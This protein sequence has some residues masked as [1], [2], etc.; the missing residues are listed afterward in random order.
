MW[1]LVLTLKNGEELYYC[2]TIKSSNNVKIPLF[3]DQIN[4][5]NIFD[6]NSSAFNQKQMITNNYGLNGYTLEVTSSSY[7]QVLM[8]R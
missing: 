6:K 1:I 7:I 2:R 3:T 5:I 8:E 4:K